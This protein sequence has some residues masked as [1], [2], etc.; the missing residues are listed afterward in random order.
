MPR[1]FKNPE[2]FAVGVKRDCSEALEACTLTMINK[3]DIIIPE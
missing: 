3:I 1:Y 2:T